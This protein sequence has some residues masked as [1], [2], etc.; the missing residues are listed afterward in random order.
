V[1]HQSSPLAAL[2]AASL[3]LG[4]PGCATDRYAEV[5]QARDAYDDCVDGWGADHERCVSLHDSLQNAEER[6]RG[7]NPA[8]DAWG[9]CSASDPECGG[10]L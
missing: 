6:Y 10:K 2:V 3:L 1:K 4:L 8:D 9:G 7:R 5:S